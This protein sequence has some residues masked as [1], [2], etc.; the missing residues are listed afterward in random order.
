MPCDGTGTGD[1]ATGAVDIG[2]FLD[3]SGNPKGV[4]LQAVAGAE[5]SAEHAAAPR[6]PRRVRRAHRPVV[7][8]D[9]DPRCRLG[10]DRRPVSGVDRRCRREARCRRRAGARRASGARRWRRNAPGDPAVGARLR[11]SNMNTSDSVM[12][13]ALHPVDLDTRVTRRTP[14]R[15]AADV[16]DEVDGRR[17]PARGW[18]APAGRSPAM[19]T[20]VS[21]RA[22][23]SRGELACSVDSEPSWPVFMAWSMSSASAPRTSPTTMRSGRM[24]SA[25]RTR[26]RTSDLALAL[27]VG[28]AALEPDHV[29]LLRAAARPRPRWSRCARSRG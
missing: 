22:S 18:R 16:H 23:A 9:R 24:R 3:T 15:S 26:S 20:M 28:R 7:D 14:S 5:A 6:R 17:R 21:S 19:S 11:A 29:V 4:P 12:S 2:Q 1:L 25:L 13:L 10:A 8:L 27:D